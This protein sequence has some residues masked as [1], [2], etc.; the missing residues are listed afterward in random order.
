[1][2]RFALEHSKLAYR[3]DFVAYALAV[4]VIAYAL[5]AAGPR[6]DRPV[7]ATLVALGL[8]GWSLLEYVAHRF[9]LHSVPPFSTWHMAHH[10]RPTA[11]ICTPT[12]LSGSLIALLVFL[13]ALLLSNLW[14]GSA[15]TLGV[16]AGYL[17]YSCVHH[18]VHHWHG[19][20]RW[21]RQ[22]KYCH[23]MHHRREDAG[24]YGV[25][26]AFWDVVFHTLK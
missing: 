7:M 16:L 12:L 20:G 6:A 11:L 9:V 4:V 5:V 15:L 1:M 13:P 8:L 14:R 21:L 22:R 23:A 2:G 25:T 24:Y 18:A 3:A 19:G 17:A 10:E 26:T